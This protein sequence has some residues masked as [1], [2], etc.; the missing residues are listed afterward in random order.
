MLTKKFTGAIALS[1]AL[2]AGS[3]LAEG[4][5]KTDQGH[6]EIIFSWDHVGITIQSGEFETAEGTLVLADDIEKS[7]IEVV[8]DANS[9]SSGF[10]ALDDHLKTADFLDVE[11]YPEITFKST[12]VKMTGD[13]TM[14]VTG[15]LTIHGVTNEVVLDA[16]MTLNGPHPLGER[17]EYY[18]GDWVAIK[19]STEID[20]QSFDVGAF[21]TGPITITINTEMK[22]AE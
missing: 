1:A 8:I 17:I 19:A 13:N 15:D 4:T 20:H 9:V 2:V 7:S 6:T 16:E 22:E 18:Q 21:S 14:D 3:A 5:F 12:S 10:E 11:K